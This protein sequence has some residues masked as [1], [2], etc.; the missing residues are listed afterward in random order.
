[1][2]IS[3]YYTVLPAILF[4]IA[5]VFILLI[6][7]FI[8]MRRSAPSRE[9]SGAIALTIAAIIL[10]SGIWCMW[11][12]PTVDTRKYDEIATRSLVVEPLGTVANT[13]EAEKGQEIEVNI[14][15]TGPVRV[16]SVPG[17]VEQPIYPIFSVDIYDPA[18]K[19]VW[20]QTNTTRVFMSSTPVTETGIYRVEVGNPREEAVSLTMRVQDRTKMTIRPL[21]PIGQWLSLISIPIFALGVWL[22]RAKRI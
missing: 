9:T 3:P 12:S 11:L 21:E 6:T 19:L 13:F 5:M 18:G 16:I 22:T 4:A 7:F 15:F 17:E 20:T 10:L 14:D 8:A 2:E 1:M